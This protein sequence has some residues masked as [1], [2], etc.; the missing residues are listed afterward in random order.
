ML[1]TPAVQPAPRAGRCSGAAHCG[2]Q[3]LLPA[4][5]AG[6]SQRVAAPRPRAVVAFS[7]QGSD[8]YKIYILPSSSLHLLLCSTRQPFTRWAA[9]GR[10]APPK[11]VG[12]AGGANC[13]AAARVLR[14]RYCRHDNRFTF[15]LKLCC[16]VGVVASVALHSRRSA[17]SDKILGWKTP[18]QQGKLAS[19]SEL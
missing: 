9:A 13:P 11:R 17:G 19:I 2:S 15:A 5:L 10:F 14:Q 12:Q 16:L 3:L 6:S 18:A 7:L 8:Y 4:G 1:H